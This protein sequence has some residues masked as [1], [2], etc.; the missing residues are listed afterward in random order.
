[1]KR[2]LDISV[3]TPYSTEEQPEAKRNQGIFQG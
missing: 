2:P 3:L 1:M